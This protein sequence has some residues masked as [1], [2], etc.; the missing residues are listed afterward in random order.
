M[1]PRLNVGSSDQMQQDGGV[2][3]VRPGGRRRIDRVLAQDYLANLGERTLA[4]VREMR[5]DADQEETD[6]SYVRR[7]LHAR[8]DIVK[9]E[10][11]RRFEGG[12][13]AVVE[14][15]AEILSENAVNSAAAYGRYQHL[16]P[17]RAESHRRQVEALVSDVDLS[18]VA[19]LTDVQLDAALTAFTVEEA[20]V[21][22][23][24]R[25]VQLVVDKL[26]AEIA[27][28]YQR[29]VASVDELLAS[30]RTPNPGDI[31]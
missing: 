9:A 3:E 7:L 31:Q 28:R 21:S 5:D 1:I 14:Q 25:E 19:S 10:Q 8:I 24:R 4:E 20:S 16:E 15:L 23:Y 13:T 27:D 2:I 26:N 22:R 12:S 6:L 11:A 17:S 29:G 30:E 18:D